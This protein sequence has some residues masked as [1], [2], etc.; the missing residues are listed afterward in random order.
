MDKL[1]GWIR[2]YRIVLLFTVAKLVI[3]LLTAT[4]YGLHRDA[5]LYLAQS[6]HL[7]WGYYS[8]PPL[9][10]LLVR[11]H[12]AIWGDSVLAVRLLPALAGMAAIFIVGWLIRQLKGGPRAQL[13]G[14]GAYLLSPAFLR[15]AA[16]L[17]PVVFNHLFWL[18][19]VVVV[20]R[21]V[22][23]EDPRQ[24]LWMIPVL[25]LGWLNKYAIIFY[26]LALLAALV[27]SRQRA[28]L[29]SRFLPLTLAGGLLVILPNL[30]W[31]FQHNW[32]VISHMTELQ[33]TQHHET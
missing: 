11:I 4:N 16:L 33:E 19:A 2:E 26:A 15:P 25:G 20:F 14:M 9:L 29:W 5:Y 23:R 30:W 22:R 21:M 6:Q 12:T 24:L 28:L 18:L 1:R 3:H 31:Q 17:Q 32:P 10:A 8:S 27:I 13:I 7:D